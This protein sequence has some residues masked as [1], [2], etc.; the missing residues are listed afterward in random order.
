MTRTVRVIIADDHEA[1]RSGVAAILSTDTSIEV[2]AEA[3]NGFDALAAAHRH[4]PDVALVDLRMPGTDGIWAISRITGETG[5]R[6]IALTTFDSDDLVAAALAAGAHGYLLKSTSGV[7][8]IQ[9][10]HHVA[11][12][13]HVV[14][15]A[16]TGGLIARAAT[17]SQASGTDSAGRSPVLADLTTRE[18]QVLELVTRGLGNQA[19]ADELHIGVTT[20]KTHVGSLYAKSGVDSRV[21]LARWGE[22]ILPRG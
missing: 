5:T 16:I 18:R 21:R 13:R 1:V 2:L 22:S 12:D 6:V 20:V 19:I 4:S 7:E 14:D 15:P 17:A 10:V 11:A 8:L 9:A 3:E